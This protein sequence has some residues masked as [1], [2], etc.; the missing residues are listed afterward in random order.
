MCQRFPL[1]LIVILVVLKVSYN[2]LVKKIIFLILVF[3]LLISG[4]FWL[5]NKKITPQIIENQTLLV[6]TA[7]KIQKTT[8]TLKIGENI[9]NI[10]VADTD[11][12]RELGLSGKEG[13]ALNEAMLFVFNTPGYYGIWMKDM[14]FAIDIAWL[15]KNKK[16]IY[17]KENVSPQTYPEVFT[18]QQKSLPILSMYV[19]ETPANYFE[20]SKIKIG[21]LVEF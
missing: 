1:T 3:I 11:I 4:I 2:D 15:D 18:A 13:L 21:D 16:I 17:L 6:E 10:E 14:N 12:K 7:E 5:K 20:N 9:L 8:K 19:L